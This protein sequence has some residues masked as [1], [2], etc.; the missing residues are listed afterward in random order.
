MSGHNKWTQIK[1][2]KGVTDKRRGKLFTKLLRAITAAAKEESD[3]KYNPRLRTAIT[4]AKDYS[5]PHENI[6]RAVKKASIPGESLDE[7]LIE[8]Y[9]KNG[10]A[11]LIEAVTDNRNRTVAEIKKIFHDHDAKWAENGSVQW[12]F[13][14]MS[15]EKEEQIWQPRF[16]EEIQSAQK[17]DLKKLINSLEERED[18]QKIFV[19][20]I[21]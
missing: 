2:Q 10:T 8:A 7:L 17:E 3:P 18:V 6:E 19:N 20:A 15:N 16:P 5:V 4:K 14:R 12:V 21:L 13:I 11:I 9:D 1:H